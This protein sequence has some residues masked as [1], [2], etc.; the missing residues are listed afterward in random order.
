M[1]VSEIKLCGMM[2][3]RAASSNVFSY[4]APFLWDQATADRKVVA[5]IKKNLG[6]SPDCATFSRSFNRENLIYHVEQKSSKAKTLDKI[7][8][9]IRKHENEAG[10]IYCTSR[11][12]TEMVTEELQR[13][14]KGTSLAKHVNFYHA[15]LEDPDLRRKRHLD[16][17]HDNCRV[18]VATVAFGMGIDKPDV[19]FVI[20]YSLPK[21][22]IHYYQESG[23]AGRDGLQ[24]ICTLYYSFSDKRRVDWLIEQSENKDSIHRQ[25]VAL[26]QMVLFCEDDVHCRRFKLLRHFG[27]N[28]DAKKCKGTCDNCKAKCRVKQMDCTKYARAIVSAVQ[29][30]GRSANFTMAHF[31]SVFRGCS[32]K[33]IKSAGHDRSPLF[34]MG[35]GF[36]VALCN[37]LFHELIVLNYL[38]EEDVKNRFNGYSNT[39]LRAGPLAGKF[40]RGHNEKFVLAVR[41]EKRKLDVAPNRA[42]ARQVDGYNLR[43]S[44]Q[45]HDALVRH[46]KSFRA[47]IAALRQKSAFL[48]L[49]N[50]AVIQLAVRLPKTVEELKA[51]DGISSAKMETAEKFM[52]EAWR[53][54]QEDAGNVKPSGMC[55]LVFAQHGSI[56]H[57]RGCVPNFRILT[58]KFQMQKHSTGSDSRK[59]HH[60]AGDAHGKSAK[61]PR[62]RKAT[63]RVRKA[64]TKAGKSSSTSRSTSK[65]GKYSLDSDS[66]ELWDP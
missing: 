12:D 15:G 58:G 54:L 31:I 63:T 19:R 32:T 11:K 39:Y 61:K 57:S 34:K 64:S 24:S 43:V 40:L 52:K 45:T 18:I 13:R 4:C 36:K 25:K 8:T 6:M 37:R 62:K 51:I 5:H 47:G 41:G 49:N 20:H 17:Q 27:E 60:F 16:W 28:F 48:V 46:L 35:K 65:R 30:L 23:R 2:S 44:P 22:L 10:I 59:S 38:Q 3:P 7:A 66:D 14:F 26:N 53:F 56:R 50:Q 1:P 55:C 9:F 33:K 21:S 29:T 42:A